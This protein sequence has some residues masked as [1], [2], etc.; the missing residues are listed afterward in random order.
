MPGTGQHRPLLRM[1]GKELGMQA[2]GHS[3]PQ[4]KLPQHPG[5]GTMSC[6]QHP[7]PRPPAPPSE[8]PSTVGASFFPGARG[9]PA[10]GASPCA[11]ELAF[12][13]WPP[14][15]GPFF[16]QLS[17]AWG[18]PNLGETQSQMPGGPGWTPNV[19]G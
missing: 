18:A 4:M 19:E 2:P 3:E 15:S 11:S 6:P 5:Q 13:S 14:R 16:E 17:E 12:P 10:P 7:Q 1:A 9:A 8:S